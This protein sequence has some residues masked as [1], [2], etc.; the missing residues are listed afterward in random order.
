MVFRRIRCLDVPTI[1]LQNRDSLS[2][3]MMIH[4]FSGGADSLVAIGI[5]IHFLGMFH[6]MIPYFGLS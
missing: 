5:M 3:C 1:M 4:V 6:L 2:G